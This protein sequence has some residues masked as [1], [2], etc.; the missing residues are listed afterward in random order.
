MLSW[1][2]GKEA[3]AHRRTHKQTSEQGRHEKDEKRKTAWFHYKIVKTTAYYG[4]WWF[5]WLK[6]TYKCFKNSVEIMTIWG[7]LH[8]HFLKYGI[9]WCKSFTTF[10]QCCIHT[11]H[12]YTESIRSRPLKRRLNFW[13]KWGYLTKKEITTPPGKFLTKCILHCS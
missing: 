5:F 2:E 9:S 4:Y 6:Y 11:T 10:S 8:L 1:E 12:T 3:S 7:P 13:G